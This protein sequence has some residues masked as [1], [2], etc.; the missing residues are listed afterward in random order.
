MK[1]VLGS[2]VSLLVSITGYTQS[3]REKPPDSA[4]AARKITEKDMSDVLHHILKPGQV[5]SADNTGLKDTRKHFSFVPAIGYTLQTGFA[6]IAS[7]NLAFYNDTLARSKISSINTSITYSQY[8]QIIIPLQVN[9]WTRG[10][11]FNIISDMRFIDYPSDIYGLGE[12]FDPDKGYTIDFLGLKVH[13]TLI[14]ALGNN[15]YLGLGYYFDKFWRIR[16]DDEDLSV[17]SNEQVMN[18]LGTDETASGPAFR[19]MYDTRLNQINPRQG[20]Y[21]NVTYRASMKALGSGDNWQSMQMDTRTYFHFPAQSRNVIAL[22][23]FDW[24]TTSGTPPYLLLPSTGWDDNYNTGR[25]Y[26]QGRFR[27]RNMFYFESEYRF[28][29]TSNGL[30]GGVAFVNL[31]NFSGDLSRKY[32]NLFPG[33]GAGLRLK[34]NKYSGANLAVDYGFGQN[35]SRGFFVNLGEVF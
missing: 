25:G 23:M 6:A 31:E 21:Y 32:N 14:R 3:P 22:W 33:Y 34:L 18:R 16:A 12:G 29:I 20:L 35:G 11:R 7:A 27:G 5:M 19:F 8:N 26:I 1:F 17:L 28:N 13:E 9:L 4:I 24:L 15:I 30:L 2:L 10:N